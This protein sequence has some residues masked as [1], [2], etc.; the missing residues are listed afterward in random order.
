M[1]T[2]LLPLALSWLAYFCIHSLLASIAS[3]QFIAERWPG[4]MPAYRLVFNLLAI[5]LLAVPLGL[6]FSWAGPWLWQWVGI[7]LWISLALSLLAIAG[8]LWSL[9][10]YDMEEFLG[11][12]Q[13]SGRVASVDDQEHFHLS[14]LHRWVRHPWYFFALLLIWTRDMHAAMLLSAVMM[15]LYFFIGSRLEERKLI[16]YHGEQYR[17]YRELVPGLIPLPWKYLRKEQMQKLLAER[18]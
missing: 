11:L 7:W 8:F 15:T 12:R 2:S 10:Y 1:T 14:P 3:K 18:K 6:T 9:R 13:L 5:L 17:R 4:G 16:R